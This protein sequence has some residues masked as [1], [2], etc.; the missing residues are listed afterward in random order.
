MSKQQVI[1]RER[2]WA[3]PAAI[4]ALLPLPL[5]IASL[6]IVQTA[7]LTGGDSEGDQIRSV[8]DHASAVTL[9]PIPRAIALVLIIVPFIYLFR[10]AQARNPRV[11]AALVGFAVL[12]PLL[13]AVQGIVSAIAV[14]GVADDYV[15]ATEPTG[16]Y[17][18][19]ISEVRKSPDSIDSVTLY[20]EQDRIEVER[21]GANFSIVKYPGNLGKDESKLQDQLDNKAI[22]NESDSSGKPGDDL[23]QQ[24]ISDSSG[25]QVSQGL[26]FPAIL[27]F[28]IGM[29][30]IP[31]QATRAGLLTRFFGT[32]G[33]ALGAS[34]ILLPQVSEL[35]I[36]IWFAFLGLLFVNRVPGG[37]PPAWEAGE[38]IPWPKPGEEAAAR[39]SGAAVE[40]S[41]TEVTDDASPGP[42]RQPRKRKRRR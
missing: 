38:A 3:R 34:L 33:M 16:Q 10:A 13:L 9:S 11:Q 7:G 42:Q 21:T 27:G 26:L 1:E 35:A 39:R 2:R 15:S 30:Y 36:L 32:L 17:K 5:Y 40:G 37:R 22:D 24:F 25:I 12:G 23:A 19:F 14:T 8:H 31:L 29:I 18:A 28:I 6:A 4:A 41:A 20:P